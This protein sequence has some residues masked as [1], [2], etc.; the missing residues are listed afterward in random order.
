MNEMQPRRDNSNIAP[1]PNTIS[2]LR[3][4]YLHQEREIE[5]EIRIWKTIKTI[6]H[7]PNRLIRISLRG[8]VAEPCTNTMREATNR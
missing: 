7:S 8:S 6:C 3:D 5:T 2:H 4:R 1:T